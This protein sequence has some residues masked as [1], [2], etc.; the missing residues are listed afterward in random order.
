MQAWYTERHMWPCLCFSEL[1]GCTVAQQQPVKAPASPKP[2]L[3]N[4]T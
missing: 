3:T 1:L 4:F 2:D